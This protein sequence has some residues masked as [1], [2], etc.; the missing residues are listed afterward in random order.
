MTKTCGAK[1][2][3]AADAKKK[4]DAAQAQKPPKHSRA[5]SA[6]KKPGDPPSRA[7]PAKTKSR[8]SRKRTTVQL[9]GPQEASSSSESDT[10]SGYSTIEGEAHRAHDAP[11]S[12]PADDKQADADWASSVTE[13]EI[14]Q[15]P[16]R[17]AKRSPPEDVSNE[18]D[19][20]ESDSEKGLEQG[21][22][23]DPNASPKLT[24]QQLALHPGSPMTPRSKAAV[25]RNAERAKAEPARRITSTDREPQVITNVCSEDDVPLEL[26][27]RD[28]RQHLSER[29]RDVKVATKQRRD[30]KR[31]HESATPRTREQLLALRYWS[32][33]DYSEYLRRSREP[34]HRLPHY[35][36]CPV[37][38]YDDTGLA[39]QSYELEFTQWLRHLGY[40]MPEFPDS[41]YRLDWLAQ[42]R[43]RFR[44]AKMVVNGQWRTRS[45]DR[46]LPTPG[47]I[48]E[49]VLQK[50]QKSWQS[51]PI[52]PRSVLGWV[53]ADRLHGNAHKRP[54]GRRS[55]PRGGFQTPTCFDPLDNRATSPDT[56]SD[57]Y[58]RG[59]SV[60]SRHDSR[61]RP[62]YQS[63]GAGDATDVSTDQDA[64]RHSSARGSL[65]TAVE[66]C[67]RLL[68]TQRTDLV[69]LRGRVH[70]VESTVESRRD[71]PHDLGRLERGAHDLRQRADGLEQE[72][73]QVARRCSE[74]EQALQEDRG[75]LR[76]H[77]HWI[78]QLYARV[79]ALEDQIPQ[80][81]AAPPAAPAPP[82]ADLMQMMASVLRQYSN[83]SDICLSRVIRLEQA[84]VERWMRGHG[85]WQ[86]QCVRVAVDPNDRERPHESWPR[87]GAAHR[88]DCLDR[89]I[90]SVKKM[91][92]SGITKLLTRSQLTNGCPDCRLSEGVLR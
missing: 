71:V 18:V 91:W 30:S 85:R 69:S 60:S 75:A 43:L 51:Q 35:D 28:N 10:D 3:S 79:G 92:W 44:M 33:R 77:L 62:H 9:P 57:R 31:D 13:M 25:E 46:N 87:L 26:L 12:Q 50:V 15:G 47:V 36:E 55:P 70:L 34:G 64:S 8:S 7:K 88:S 39:R 20:D 21:E 11:D 80:R 41:P 5:K 17:D 76:D 45:F 72:L 54:R 29:A 78:R 40:P 83:S 82:Q 24:E 68:E 19:Y 81:T 84:H 32:V 86:V 6:S 14:D 61:E 37:V 65:L 58:A 74:S 16:I 89:E 49:E 42:R 52:E 2:R 63:V 67:Q 23:N 1:A 27:Q 66:G 38:L 22:V 4:G 53:N 48:L 56:G 59:A 73:R 90:L